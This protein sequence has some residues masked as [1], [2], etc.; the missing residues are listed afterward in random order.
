MKL[1]YLVVLALENW[2]KS[3]NTL[4]FKSPVVDEV[5]MKPGH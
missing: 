5:S 3:S 1:Q 2:G 4:S